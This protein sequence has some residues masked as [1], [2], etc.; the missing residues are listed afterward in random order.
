MLVIGLV[1]CDS[2]YSRYGGRCDVR[3]FYL[4][5]IVYFVLRADSGVLRS[6]DRISRA[7]QNSFVKRANTIF[8]ILHYEI[9][10]IQ[11]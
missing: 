10:T 5:E 11:Y 9:N 1:L 2:F 6:R 8:T 4:V 3:A 7:I